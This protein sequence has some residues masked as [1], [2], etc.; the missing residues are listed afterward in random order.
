VTQYQRRDEIANAI[1]RS[2]IAYEAV[3]KNGRTVVCVCV[4]EA[5]VLTQDPV[6]ASS[7]GTPRVDEAAS[8]LA[9][10]GSGQYR[11]AMVDGK[12][13]GGCFQFAITFKSQQ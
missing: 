2:A 7:S 8:R 9:K 3:P 4:D 12:P 11:P 13:A 6:I 10:S 1:M 5:G